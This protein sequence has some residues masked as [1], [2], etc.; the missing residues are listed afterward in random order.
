MNTRRFLPCTHRPAERA[1]RGVV[2]LVALLAMV[3]MLV[4]AVA[5]MRSFTT[6]MNITGNAA[7]KRDLAN[8]AERAMAVAVQLLDAG[9]LA[10]EAAREASSTATN[11][12]AAMLATNAQGIP[13]A[14][15]NDTAFAAVGL[16]SNDIVVNEQ[17][18]RVRWVLDRL[19]TGG[20][21]Q[22][23]LGA[24]GCT[25]GPTPDARGGSASDPIVA[26]QQP[27][28]LYRV[29]IRVDGPRRTQAFFQS[30]LAL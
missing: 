11:Y 3:I 15:L 27:Q 4:G 9:A 23:A 21:S 6:S 22:V 26:T 29:S 2:M 25:V 10:T 17:G 14:L 5:L 20:G 24:A 19:C 1:Q 30:T 18:V 13:L 7:I 12:S 8:Q 16:G 28:V